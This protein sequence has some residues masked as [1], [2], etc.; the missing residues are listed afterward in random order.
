MRVSTMRHAPPDVRLALFAN[1]R[2]HFAVSG[3]VER[4]HLC[5]GSRLRELLFKFV[6]GELPLWCS[7][8]RQQRAFAGR[9]NRETF[10]EP[11]RGTPTTKRIND[12]VRV[13]MTKCRR[14]HA[15]F[16]QRG[17]RLQFNAPAACGGRGPSGL[18]RCAD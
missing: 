5:G 1:E 9:V 15:A 16:A 11:T 2:A 14:Q 13:F 17:E 8:A 4:A 18:T 12:G 10:G 3:S 6:G 7:D